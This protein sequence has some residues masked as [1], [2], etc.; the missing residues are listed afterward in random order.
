MIKISDKT[1]NLRSILSDPP[2]DWS[3]KRRRN[4]FLWAQQVVAGLQ[5]VNQSLD[6]CVQSVLQEG[7]QALSQSDPGGK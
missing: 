1:C 3:L 5:G 7:L 4:Y 2:K 6:D